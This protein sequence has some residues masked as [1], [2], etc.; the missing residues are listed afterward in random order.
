M[1]VAAKKRLLR[2]MLFARRFEERCYEAYVERKIGGFLHLYSGEE[3]CAHG[4]LEA[5]NI[6]SDYVITSYRDHIHA[7]KSGMDPKEV[8]A[9]LYAKETGCCK[10]LGGSMHIFGVEHRFMGGYA[11]VGGPFPL[12]AGLAK[13]IK[14]KG[15]SEICIC[16]LGDAANN[17]GT[18]HESLNMAK[19]WNLP[20]LYVC[21][22]NLYGIGTRI[23]RSTAVV[24]QYK[25]V[26]GYDIPSEQV[27]GQD[28]EVVYAA[29]Q[30]AINHVRSGKGPYFLELMTYRY[31][32]HSMSDSNAYRA[33]DEE[34]VWSKRDPIIMLRDR[35]VEAGEITE[36]DYKKM[37]DEILEDI[38][39]NVIKFSEESPEPSMDLLEKY[40]LAEN[41]P[42]VHG[43]PK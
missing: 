7:I 6:G 20:V 28:V 40:V 35:L 5:A 33:K 29:A 26:S 36:D 18:F 27:D 15:G 17:Q 39:N 22:N 42:W 43:G 31:R 37:D 19:I 9:E 30:K 4:V 13:G 25:R 21:E 24:D 11:L 38:E 32:G 2:E 14:M 10:G 3:A 1:D 12:A 16:F 34:R 23:D 8:M 41:D